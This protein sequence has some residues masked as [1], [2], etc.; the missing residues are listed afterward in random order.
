M[1]NQTELIDPAVKGTILNI[2][3]TCKKASSLKRVVLTS[4]TAAVLGRQFGPNDVVD[5]TFFSDP[6]LCMEMKVLEPFCDLVIKFMRFFIL[7]YS[8]FFFVENFG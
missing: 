8:F 7:S 4:S 6:S 2:L 1:F 5:E 3:N